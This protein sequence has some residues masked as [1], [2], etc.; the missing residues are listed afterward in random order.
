MSRATYLLQSD[1]AELQE[2]AMRVRT[3]FAHEMPYL[4]GSALTSADYR[5]VDVRLILSNKHY[6][7]LSA[8][9]SVPLLNL[10][11]STW[12]QKV[13]RLP[14]D[15]QIQRMSEAN[16]EFSGRRHPL[17]MFSLAEEERLFSPP[18]TNNANKNFESWQQSAK[19]P[20]E[21]PK[22][23]NLIGD[24]PPTKKH[25]PNCSN[26]HDRHIQCLECI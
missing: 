24:L 5:D 14:I 25:E 12:G 22:A 1:L 8:L 3:M 11:V 13:T 19:N 15:F 17:A 2:W 21:K 26:C 20:P 16:S 9:V 6:D 4:V 23:K 10:S 18:K 7:K